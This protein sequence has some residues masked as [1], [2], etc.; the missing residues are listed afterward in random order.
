MMMTVLT[1]SSVGI[2]VPS[3]R[4]QYYHLQFWNF[5]L[6]LY[7][8]S[9]SY[10][11]YQQKV[12]LI[13]DAIPHV[14]YHLINDIMQSNYALPI[15]QVSP[16]VDASFLQAWDHVAAADHHQLLVL[17][18]VHLPPSDPFADVSHYSSFGPFSSSTIASS[19]SVTAVC[20][21]S[22]EMYICLYTQ[23]IQVTVLSSRLSLLVG[24]LHTYFPRVY[25]MLLILQLFDHSLPTPIPSSIYAE[26]QSPV[27]IQRW[28]P[29]NKFVM[30]WISFVHEIALLFY[31][32]YY[33][34]YSVSSSSK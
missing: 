21:Y 9:I 11:C 14:Q 22:A 8:L 23:P 33:L 17:L 6:L 16:P 18:D 28:P 24:V 20:T 13:V 30:T 34:P 10:Y 29:N 19:P 31:Y 26:G 4:Y 3:M 27:S 7:Q 12:Q 25:L 1:A 15:K 5:F 2:V 32:Y